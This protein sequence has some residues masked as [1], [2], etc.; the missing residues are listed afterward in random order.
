MR[1]AA[2]RLVAGDQELQGKR[3]KPVVELTEELELLRLETGSEM[4]KLR[5]RAANT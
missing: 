2:W 1:L 5:S 3:G 4:R